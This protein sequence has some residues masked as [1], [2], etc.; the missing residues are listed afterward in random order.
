[1]HSTGGRT[2]K[3]KTQE[4]TA[5][6]A[7]SFTSPIADQQFKLIRLEMFEKGKP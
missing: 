4:E 5:Q 3:Y 2:P 7:C 1:M 6:R